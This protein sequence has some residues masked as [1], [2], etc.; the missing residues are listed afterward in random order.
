MSDN[1]PTV[2]MFRKW[3]ASQGGGVIALFPYVPAGNSGLLCQSFEH[4]GQHGGANLGLVIDVT[5]PAGPHEYAAL[6]RELESPPYGYRL[7]VRLRTPHDAAEVRRR[8]ARR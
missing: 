7:T 4:I 5:T 8:E 3:P 1:E 2:V 6:R